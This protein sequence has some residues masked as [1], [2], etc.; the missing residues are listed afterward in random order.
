MMM[1]FGCFVGSIPNS[2]SGRRLCQEFTSHRHAFR[3]LLQNR[4]KVTITIR[5]PFMTAIAHHRVNTTYFVALDIVI[6]EIKERFTVDD[7][8][9]LCALGDVALSNKPSEDSED[10]VANFYELNKDLIQAE[11]LFVFNFLSQSAYETKKTPIALAQFMSEKKLDMILPTFFRLCKFLAVI[12]A[13][14]C[15]MAQRRLNCLAVRGAH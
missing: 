4:L 11:R 2:L 14:S 3:L 10:K 1:A 12:M 9:I 15:S 6:G 8:D 7:Q 5:Q 13:T